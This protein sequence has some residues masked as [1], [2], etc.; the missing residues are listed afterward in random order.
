MKEAYD[1]FFSL[2]SLSYFIIHAKV[3][4]NKEKRKGKEVFWHLNCRVNHIR[5]HCTYFSV[6][7]SDF[8]T[9]VERTVIQY[10]RST[11]STKIKRNFNIFFSANAVINTGL[12]KFIEEEKKL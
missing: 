9:A 4:R 12:I 11:L 5:R 6:L 10:V 3:N 2:L 8:E 7:K 1:F